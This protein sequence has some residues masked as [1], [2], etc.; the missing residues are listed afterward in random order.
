[1]TKFQ[2]VETFS[3]VVDTSGETTDLQIFSP[4]GL[5]LDEKGVEAIRKWKF[6]PARKD[7]KPVRVKIG[8]ETDFHLN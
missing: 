2:V 7:G 8:V 3:V 5:G 6:E 4:L 1:M